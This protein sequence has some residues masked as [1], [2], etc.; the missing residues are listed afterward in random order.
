LKSPTITLTNCH[1][2]A[3]KKKKKK[4]HFKKRKKKMGGKHSFPSPGQKREH[5]N[6]T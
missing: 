2:R 3:T 6:L 5:E 1:Q 4:R